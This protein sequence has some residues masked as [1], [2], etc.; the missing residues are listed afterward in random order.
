MSP[1]QGSIP[2][3]IIPTTKGRFAIDNPNV[4]SSSQI[5]HPSLDST[6]QPS[7]PSAPASILRKVLF[8]LG[9][10]TVG[11]ALNSFPIQI[12]GE[13]SLY[14]GGALPILATVAYGPAAGALVATAAFFG[15]FS[16][17]HDP[18]I[19]VLAVIEA[20]CVGWMVRHRTFRPWTATII[21]WLVL[22]IPMAAVHIFSLSRLPYPINWSQLI[23]LPINAGLNIIIYLPLLNCR[24]FWRNTRSTSRHYDRDASLRGLLLGRHIFT[25]L[26]PIVALS[27]VAGYTLN[28]RQLESFRA[29]LAD[30]AEEI[31]KITETFTRFWKLHLQYAAEDLASGPDTQDFRRALLERVLHRDFET[32]WIVLADEAGNVL[33]VAGDY[34]ETRL[35][36]RHLSAAQKAGNVAWIEGQFDG[37]S[38]GSKLSQTVGA[39][40]QTKSGERRIIVAEMNLNS[41]AQYL[42]NRISLRD[43]EFFLVDASGSHVLTNS[44]GDASRLD[45]SRLGAI[46]NGTVI[47]DVLSSDFKSS[48]RYYGARKGIESTGATVY[49]RAEF[50]PEGQMLAQSY[51]AVLLFAG[52]AAAIATL[53]ALNVSKTLSHPLDK[54][55]EFTAALSRRQPASPLQF[56]NPVVTEWRGLATDL[57]GAAQNLADSNQSLEKAVQDRDEAVARL[58]VLTEE[59]DIRV[60]TRTAELEAARIAAENASQAK[61]DFLATVSHELRTPLNVVLGHTFLLLRNPAEPLPPKQAERVARIRSST[62]HLLTLINEILDLAKLSAGRQRLD[63]GPVDLAALGQECAEFFR[64]ECERSHLKLSCQISPSLPTF[65]GDVKRLRQV[66]LNLLGNAVKFTPAGG[67]V[68]LKIGALPNQQGFSLEIWDSGIGI[69]AEQQQRLFRPFEQIDNSRNRKY[70][71]T[72]LG[73]AIVKHLTDLHGGTVSVQSA[74]GQGSRFTI[75]LP[76]NAPSAEV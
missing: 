44:S 40:Y 22:G 13:V 52:T 54:L 8:C 43:R 12:F 66:L 56:S 46:P 31:G 34:L 33:A 24:C 59:L 60:K 21:F 28:R 5:P 61:S 3:N 48:N 27:L 11:Y 64:D 6:T 36:P 18:I 39:S 75:H 7:S 10:S 1:V 71:G 4:P 29:S 72:G 32:N 30:Q 49:V 16:S 53:V 55:V 74:L 17:G 41:F 57:A 38:F 42:A 58:R 62:E 25:S 51:L 47:D 19:G 37:V 14:L 63:L 2:A 20:I 70:V 76:P 26:W 50:W 23:A 65:R 69:S 45:R 68:G 15:C 73:L 67:S 35:A 9:F